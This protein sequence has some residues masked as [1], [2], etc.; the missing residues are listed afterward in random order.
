MKSLSRL[1]FLVMLVATLG[2]FGCSGDD[3]KD[4]APGAPGVSS[5]QA[6]VD[7]G[8]IDPTQI[9]EEEWY[10]SLTAVAT[11]PPLAKPEECLPRRRRQ[12][13]PQ[14]QRQSSV[15]A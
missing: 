15:A 12:P 9:S 6:A 2:L 3:G 13:W 5:Y 1:L 14:H 8:Y 4:G 7:A 10:Q 11:E